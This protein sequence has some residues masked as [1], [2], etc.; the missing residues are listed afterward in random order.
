MSE[1]YQG[2]ARSIVM[3]KTFLK[4]LAILVLLSLVY[5]IITSIIRGQKMKRARK[6]YKS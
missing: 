3:G 2:Q 6:F 4:A 5:V 1:Y